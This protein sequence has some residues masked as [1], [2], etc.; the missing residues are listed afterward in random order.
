MITRTH[1]LP[2]LALA[3]VILLAVTPDAWAAAKKTA[4]PVPI[5]MIKPAPPGKMAATMRTK[6]K[7]AS[8]TMSKNHRGGHWGYK[9]AIGPDRWGGLKP[10]YKTCAD[11]KRQ[12]PLNLQTLDAA[13]LVPLRFH[14]KVSLI[15]MINTGHT[16]Q[17]NYGPGSHIMIGADRYELEQFHFHT[18]SEHQVAGRS[19]PMEIQFVHRHKSGKLAYIA[20]FV[21]PGTENLA[22]REIWTRLPAT[23]HSKAV[24]TRAVMNARDLMPSGPAYFRY[25]G[26]LTTPPCSETV[27]W[28]VMEEPV[29]FS[30]RQIAQIRRIMGENARPVQARHGRY[31]LQADGS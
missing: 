24:D 6:P 14:Y 9:G 28:I 12:S 7:G 30:T 2:V 16:V 19:F 31:L 10:A 22:A 11:G 13:R 21:A 15:E 26:S 4:K 17:A 5:P 1:R 27:D 25:S 29:R 20:V 3:A 18:P 8:A 23:P